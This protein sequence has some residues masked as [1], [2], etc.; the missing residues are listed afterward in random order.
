MPIFDDEFDEDTFLDDDE[1][2]FE[3]EEEIDF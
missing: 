1:D 3:D 2:E